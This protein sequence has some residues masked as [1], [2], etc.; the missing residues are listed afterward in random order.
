MFLDVIIKFYVA[1]NLSLD[2]NLKALP[3]KKKK[4]TTYIIIVIAFYTY[5]N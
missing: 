1:I 4:K 3:L 5:T 2:S